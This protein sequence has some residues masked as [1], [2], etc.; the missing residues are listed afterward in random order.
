MDPHQQFVDEFFR[1]PTLP[2]DTHEEWL[3]RMCAQLMEREA[4]A[5][6]VLEQQA[7]PARRPRRPPW[8]PPSNDS[9]ASTNPSTGTGTKSW[10]ESC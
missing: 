6:S 7:R 8:T 5:V 10:G 1:A 9:G 3:L 2:A 4:Q